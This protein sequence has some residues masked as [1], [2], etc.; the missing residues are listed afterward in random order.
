M[1]TEQDWWKNRLAEDIYVTLRIKEHSL[2]V[3]HGRSPQLWMR[4]ALV[5]WI[6][7]LTQRLDVSATTQHLAVYLL[8]YFLDG[9]KVD[10]NKLFLVAETC[11]ILAVKFEDN[12]R[13][14]PKFST[15]MNLVPHLAG[16]IP[17]GS[18]NSPTH[19]SY[20]LQDYRSMEQAVLH[21]FHWEL[22]V[23]VVPHFV[24]FFLQVA[25]DDDDL[26]NGLPIMSKPLMKSHVERQTL[27]F[28]TVCLQ[29]PS[30]RQ[31]TPSLLAASCVAS[32]RMS[33]GLSPTWPK[34]LELI[35]DYYLEDLMPCTQKLLKFY[36]IHQQICDGTLPV[37][38]PNDFIQHPAFPRRYIP[39]DENHA[40]GYS[41]SL[42][43]YDR[44]SLFSAAPNIP[45]SQ[46]S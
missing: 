10:F 13:E 7:M 2:Q 32:S 25:V 24:P 23:S 9:K 18:S 37:A 43:N 17:P 11:F 26:L 5:N 16:F 35:T 6:C 34:Q 29:D 22:A 46:R 28:Q 36:R 20:T 40:A 42:R 8:D 4:P 1:A 45:W 30:F 31:V 12:S 15:V 27:Y 39:N 19:P 3:Y 38:I 41:T 21:Y 44:S 33:L 14:S